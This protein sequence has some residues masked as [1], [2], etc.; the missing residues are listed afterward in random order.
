MGFAVAEREM[1]GDENEYCFVAQVGSVKAKL[2]GGV[3]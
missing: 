2:E 3:S 1:D